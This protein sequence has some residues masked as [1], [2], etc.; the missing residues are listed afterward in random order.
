MADLIKK[1]KIK[2]QD[3]TFTDYIP[4]GAEAQN[5]ST[6]DG[7]S[8][9]LKLNKKPYY[10]DNVADMKADTKLKAGDMAITLGYYTPED[11]G[12]SE[13]V[14]ISGEYTDDGGR[15]HELNNSLFAKLLV[16]D[17]KIS[18]EQFGAKGGSTNNDTIA[19][20]N[21]I[22]FCM[23]N[24]Y[25]IIFSKSYYVLPQDTTVDDKVCLYIR[26]HGQ[27]DHAFGNGIN[28]DFEGGASINTAYPNECTLIR[29]NAGQ[30]KFNKMKLVG[31]NHKTMLL[32]LARINGLDITEGQYT[33]Y[34]YFEKIHF[35]SAKTAIRMEGATYY[36]TFNT[37]LIRD[38]D[39]GL[40]IGFTKAEEEGLVQDSACNRNNFNNLTFFGIA[41]T[42]ITI[43][44]G[45]TNKFMNTN[46]EG[47][48]Y[49]VNL[50][51]PNTHKTDFPIA[52]KW[53]AE[54]NE[55]VNTTFESITRTWWNKSYGTKVINTST[56]FNPDN[57]LIRPQ[58]YIGGI[59][60]NY[61]LEKFGRTYKVCESIL[62]YTG[63]T[64]WTTYDDSDR[65]IEA[66]NFYDCI[67]S[68]NTIT[69]LSRQTITFV[70]DED[71]S[72]IEGTITTETT[73][74]QCKAIGGLVFLTG[75]IKFQP[76]VATSSIKLYFPEN[77][78]WVTH[79]Q[80][81]FG[82]VGP[83]ALP[84]IYTDYQSKAYF[85]MCKWKNDYLEIFP[86]ENGWV[87]TN[88]KYNDIY[89]NLYGFRKDVIY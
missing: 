68:S 83:I 57:W 44:Y 18:V 70:I 48:K 25:S 80:S 85:V 12:Q 87:S 23:N 21:A 51:D 16:K 89:L 35:S 52:P 71:N 20:Q 53:P 3:G 78:S 82:N 86:P 8:V 29:L 26:A 30:L 69:G 61:S 79:T 4:I 58:V 2:K 45:D 6:N 50:D 41:D 31:V 73:G 24:N 66:R 1:I 55:F 67:K 15:Y 42:G 22:D 49:C 13:Y 38:C 76:K 60:E 17:K 33:S 59:D 11:G 39:N 10:Y 37:G 5:I 64:P 27:L 14:I 36:N 19:I 9:Q 74:I 77:R 43:N 84:I 54:D 40:I 75:K 7:D 72:N 65:G 46:F 34:N 62:P 63:V 28:F 32:N 81:T 47:V 88:G 56:A